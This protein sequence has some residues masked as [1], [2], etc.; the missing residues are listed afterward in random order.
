M[1]FFLTLVDCFD[2]VPFPGVASGHGLRPRVSERLLAEVNPSLG[3]LRFLVFSDAKEVRRS[4][5]AVRGRG[6]RRFLFR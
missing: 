3:V 4:E 6:T 5:A 1:A 2:T